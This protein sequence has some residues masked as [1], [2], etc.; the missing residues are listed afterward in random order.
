[1]P[2]MSCMIVLAAMMMGLMRLRLMVRL[3]LHLLHP[4]PLMVL[5][6]IHYGMLGIVRMV[7]HVEAAGTDRR[8]VRG[9]SWRRSIGAEM[10]SSLW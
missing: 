9:G 7:V 6:P 3:V 5:T 4:K 1:M 10:L 8:I 2:Q